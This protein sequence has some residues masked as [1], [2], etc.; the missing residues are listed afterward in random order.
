MLPGAPRLPGTALV[1]LL[2]RL[3]A[4]V[5][6]PVVAGQLSDWIA[7]AGATGLRIGLTVAVPTAY[8]GVWAAIA[9]T[10][11]LERDRGRLHAI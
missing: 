3:S 4:T 1:L 5:I 8:F 10:R 11:T 6:G 7:G 9:A 2:T